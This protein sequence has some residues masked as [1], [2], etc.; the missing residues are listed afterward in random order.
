MSALGAMS[1]EDSAGAAVREEATIVIAGGGR[2]NQSTLRRLFAL[3][4]WPLTRESL[5]LD[6]CT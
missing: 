5:C 4:F 1:P 2:D 3:C 6:D